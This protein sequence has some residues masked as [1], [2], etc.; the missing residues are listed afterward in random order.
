[1]VSFAQPSLIAFALLA[2]VSNAS[3]DASASQPVSEFDIPR[4]YSTLSVYQKKTGKQIES[5]NEAPGL[6]KSVARG[7][8]DPVKKRLP[9]D[10][11][12]VVPL[13]NPGR[14]GGRIRAAALSPTTGG[15]E[16]WTARTQPLLRIC[17][18]LQD[19]CANVARDWALS[20]D[21]TE[22]TIF[23]REGMRWSDGAPFSA[24]DFLFWYEAIYRNDKILPAKPTLWNQKLKSV[25][26]IDD[27]TVRFHFNVPHAAAVS[28]L[29]FENRNYHTIP[30]APAHYLKQFHAEYNSDVDTL[31][32][33]RG[34]S[35]WVDLF[36]FVYPNEVQARWDVKVP[37]VDPWTMMRVDRVGNK[38]FDR[39]PYYWKIDTRGNQ[40]P[41]LDGQDRMLYANIE[42]IGFKTISGELDYVA[43]FTTPENFALYKMYEQRAG[44]R[45][46]M[47]FDNRGQVLADLGLN[48]NWEDPALRELFQ[49]VRFR[50]ALSLAI[51]R[52]Q[53]NEVVFFGLA[54][55]RAVTVLPEVSF[56]E[57][58]MGRNF[59]EYD[60]K[61]A[62]EILDKI[63]LQWDSR[64]RYRLRPDGKPLEMVLE[65]MEI[66]GPTGYIV[67]FLKDHWSDIGIQMT[68]KNIDQSL[69]S[70]RSG[71]GRLYVGLG[72]F[73]GSEFGFHSE[74]R[75]LM[76]YAPDWDLWM[77]SNGEA[78]S[79]PPADVKRYW[80]LTS[81]FQGF[82]IGTD[83]YKK[84]GN[85][86]LHIAAVNL[87]RIGVVGIT[88]R[89]VL[90]KRAL[91]N[92]PQRG[93][94]NYSYRF[95]MIFSPEQWYWEADKT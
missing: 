72:N 75:G 24:D 1:M 50:R 90:I 73:D 25:E 83:E 77:N 26:K 55:P 53:I 10:P 34:Y 21:N 68:V 63:G 38:Y 23:L 9:K 13:E 46:S 29:A 66:E 81:V 89:P 57:E 51:N 80:Q 54:T 52:E 58:W 42:A 27:I 94:W 17:P 7:E 39:N 92:T 62:N 15:S 28:T 87:W 18:D 93:L 11:M 49:D 19:V 31:A 37:T 60:L 48:L 41:Y 22:L 65:Y 8:L 69:Y 59:A 2:A 64:R 33:E 14:Y 3:L 36:L 20:E 95:W 6:T 5:F 70:Q 79:E 44:Y 86:L 91:K 32:T 56:Y 85:E 82:P 61:R 35:S 74:P 76:P 16:A 67:Q 45:I 47:W 30:F 71:A 84:T 43:Q 40:L 88:P 4:F 78:G 12:V